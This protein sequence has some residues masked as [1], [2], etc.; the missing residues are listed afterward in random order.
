MTE[1]YL[2]PLVSCLT[3]KEVKSSKGIFSHFITSHTEEGKERQLKN[4][5]LGSPLGTNKLK[6]IS[7]ENRSKYEEKP[8][9]CIVCL[10]PL[11]FNHRT[12]KFCGSS[13]AA[14]HNN[15]RRIESG[16]KESE[17]SKGKKSLRMKG[18]PQ[19]NHRLNY[20]R[21]S[22]CEICG[23]L[24]RNNHNKTCSD[25]CFNKLMSHLAIERIKKN[26][27]SN[28]RRDKR[29]YLEE[30]FEIW[31][32]LNFPNI[33]FETEKTIKNTELDKWY[34]VDFY[35]PH[36][37]LIVELDGKQHE[38][39]KHKEADLVRDN[40]IRNTLMIDVFRISHEEYQSG[41]KIEQLKNLLV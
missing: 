27:R 35:F 32:K 7:V 21:I 16:W 26:K 17:E 36:K 13:C 20:C 12:A 10:N 30:S 9:F 40:F 23:D 41:V 14:I 34:F 37:N 2:S 3:C 24:I 4:A 8:N 33:A 1:K 5:K 22:F 28:F 29:S 15:K 31:L 11:D 39:S 6:Q 25:K 18:V 38:K 19:I